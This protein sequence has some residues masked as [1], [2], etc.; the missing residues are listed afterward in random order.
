MS[1][2]RRK[3]VL[4]LALRHGIPI[5][6]DDCYVDLRFEGER[7]DSIASLNPEAVVYVGS[8]SKIIG[9]GMRLGYL[10]GPSQLLDRITAIRSGSG[11][12]QFGALA[13]HRFVLTGLDQ[14]IAHINQILCYKRDVMLGALEEHFGSCFGSEVSWTRPAGG[15][16]IWLSMPTAVDTARAA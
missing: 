9:P 11:V 13:V 3:A 8:F 6:E 14:H 4:E 12:S 16:F 1:S 2:E 10:A 15:L 5:L 7:V